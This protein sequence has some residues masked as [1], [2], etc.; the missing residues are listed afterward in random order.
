MPICYEPST[1]KDGRLFIFSE[2]IGPYCCN[3]SGQHQGLA[4]LT[5]RAKPYKGFLV[6]KNTSEYGLRLI[7]GFSAP[8][9]EL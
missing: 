2:D 6:Q 9:T 1:L 5:V 7:C 3:M 8:K 4:M